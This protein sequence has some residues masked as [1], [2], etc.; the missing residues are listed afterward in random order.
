VESSPSGFHELP[1]KQLIGTIIGLQLTLLLA[2]LDQTIVSTAMPKIIEHLSGFDRYAWV[3]TAYMLTSTAAVPIFGK[4]SDMYGRKWILLGGAIFF[5]LTSALCGM[6]GEFPHWLG[7]GM[8]QLIVF[9]GL[10]GI[11]GGVIFAMVFTVIGDIFP[12]AERGKYQGLFS[13]VF[14][15]SSVLG[16]TLGG[17]ITDALTWRWVFYVNMPV[18]ALA[19]AV[20]Y[21]TFPYF[22]PEG[23]RHAIDL[24]GVV[25]LLG[26]LTPLLLA[27]TWVVKDGWTSASVLT[28]LAFSAIMFCL[29]IAFEAR[30]NEPLVPLSL[31]RDS[32]VSV[33]SVSLVLTGIAM[34]GAIIFIPLFM[35]SVMGVSATVSGSLLTPMML[36]MA[37]GS[38]TSGQLVSRIGHYKRIAL[39]GLGLMTLGL[40][41][42]S[43]M[44]ESTSQMLAVGY[45]MT[46]GAGL[47]LTMPIYTLVVQNVAPWHMIGA[48][49]ASTQFFRSIGGTLGVAIFGTVMLSRF[50]EYLAHSPG[51]QK[52]A[53]V[54]SLDSI[55]LFSAI[56]TGVT[57]LLNIFLKEVPLRKT[58]G[59]TV[60]PPIEPATMS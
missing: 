56:L 52:A 32:I 34:F 50:H 58:H 46:V 22:R 17:W 40:S 18:G 14:A 6:A 15:F 42:L 37:L 20:L 9:R 13:A 49:T 44:D 16:P 7:D 28:M 39:V 45:M 2:A 54:Y 31:F 30:A 12:P 47:G 19:I 55:F 10:Q 29:F 53:L 3:T 11:G 24:G 21:F 5:V 33:S 35:Q 38:M 8:T 27:L 25:S 48:A 4:L 51:A 60:T 41:L 23:P 36:M 43:R 57:L 1:K 59:P 26:F